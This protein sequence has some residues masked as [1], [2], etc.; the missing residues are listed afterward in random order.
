[1]LQYLARLSAPEEVL[2]RARQGL[3]KTQARGNRSMSEEVIEVRLVKKPDCVGISNQEGRGLKC[4]PL[5]GGN[6]IEDS[7]RC[8]NSF[9]FIHV[10]HK[11][12]CDIDP[13]KMA[14]FTAGASPKLF[15]VFVVEILEGWINLLLS[16]ADN[17]WKIVRCSG[18]GGGRRHVRN[19]HPYVRC[20]ELGSHIIFGEAVDRHRFALFELL[21]RRMRGSAS[22]STVRTTRTILTFGKDASSARVSS[23]LRIVGYTA[24]VGTDCIQLIS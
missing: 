19:W 9:I 16:F 4:I 18:V 15:G 1:M 3:Q 7:H 10:G 8:R 14:Y 11:Q 21:K 17:R 20:D 24:A 12:L 6:R 13:V 23:I 22:R 2:T 5:F